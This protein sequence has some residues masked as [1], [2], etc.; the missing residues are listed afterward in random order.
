MNIGT[1]PARH[2]RFRPDHLAVVCGDERYTFAAFNQ[3]INRC[4]NALIEMGIGK[5]DKVA[6]LLGNCVELLEVYWACAK[7]GAVAVP[8]SS[9]LRAQ[10]LASLLRDSDSAVVIS[11]AASADNLDE[12]RDSVPHIGRDRYLLV[13]LEGEREGFRS[14]AA[15]VARETDAEPPATDIAGDEPYNII[16]SSGTTGQPK[17]IVLTHDVRAAYGMLFASTYR[18]TPESVILHAGSI[19][20]NGAF[21]TLM[22]WMFVG[23]TYVLERK[24]DV[25]AWVPRVRELGVTHTMMVPSQIVALL[26]EDDFDEAHCGSVEM[27]G[28][29]GAPLHAE[30]KQLLAKR[31]PGRFHELYGLTEGFMTT[32]DKFDFPRKPTSVGTVPPLFEMRIVD[33]EGNDLPTGTAGEI[34]G[35]GP[36]LM[37][38]YYKRDDLTA[39]AIRD[40]WLHS[41]DVGYVDEDGFLFL[42]DR[43]KDLII[44]G[45][46]NV[47]P[48]DIEEIL[49]RHPAVRECTVF[50]VESAKWGETPVAAV[51][52][53]EGESASGDELKAWTNERVEAKFQRLSEVQVKDDLPRGVTG[54]VLK[55][56]LRDAYQSPA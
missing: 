12:I 36:L 52:L 19:V 54:K 17:G 50:G 10:G 38:G 24:F 21:L 46:V 25:Q 37:S 9:L 16:Y 44:S 2:A 35:R 6:T 43:K 15:I 55:R 22:P 4:A 3:R 29:V 40:G 20:F 23:C 56:A 28:S 30:H 7:L 1:L 14:Y 18:I 5:G 47:Y 13:D 42:V 39:Q 41:G 53:K 26:H 32:L 27:L 45:G 8:L 49:V 31:M 48:R 34:I 51:V 33:D 11:A